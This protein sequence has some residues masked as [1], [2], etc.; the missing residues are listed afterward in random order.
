[1]EVHARLY[2]CI[3][4]YVYVYTYIWNKI[5]PIKILRKGKNICKNAMGEVTKIYKTSV[6]RTVAVT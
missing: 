3:T 4:V 6:V 1:M 2:L 5:I